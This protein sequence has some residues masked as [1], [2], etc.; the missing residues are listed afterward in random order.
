MNPATSRNAQRSLNFAFHHYYHFYTED[1]S[2]RVG[3]W[4]T[5]AAQSVI[6]SL[7]HNHVAVVWGHSHASVLSPE[8]TTSFKY[9]DLDLADHTTPMQWVF[10]A[11]SVTVILGI[12]DDDDNSSNNNNHRM[13]SWTSC[14]ESLETRIACHSCCW[15][16]LLSTVGDLNNCQFLS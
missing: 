16:S 8:L 6:W 15:C 10:M 12:Y 9:S 3:T 2:T 5:E 1:R 7:W 11:G 13:S 14:A 4:W